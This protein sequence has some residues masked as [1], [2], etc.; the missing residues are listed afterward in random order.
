MS[1][2]TV[3]RIPLGERV[4]ALVFQGERPIRAQ[5]GQREW[6]EEEEQ[7]WVIRGGLVEVAV[8]VALRV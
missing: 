3:H 5:S 8:V 4:R 7:E 6:R 2:L 1:V